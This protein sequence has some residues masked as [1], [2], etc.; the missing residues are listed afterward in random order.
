VIDTFSTS[1]LSDNVPRISDTP[2]PSDRITFTAAQVQI[3]N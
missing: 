3:P 1:R 2:P